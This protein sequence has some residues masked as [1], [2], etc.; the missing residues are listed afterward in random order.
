[1]NINLEE[2]PTG[3]W[4][5]LSPEELAGLNQLIKNSIKTEEASK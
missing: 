4:R 3:S 1:M 5:Y 2:L